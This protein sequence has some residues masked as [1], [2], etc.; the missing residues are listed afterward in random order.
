[1]R[2]EGIDDVEALFER[3]KRS[4]RVVD[5]L[6]SVLGRGGSVAAKIRL[7]LQIACPPLIEIR[8][9]T[10]GVYLRRH[11]LHDDAE[12][13]VYLHE[14]LQPDADREPHDH[15]WNG[16]SLILSGGYVEERWVPGDAPWAI[17]NVGWRI[18]RTDGALVGIPATTYHR[19]D[20]VQP[21]TFTLVVTSPK[22]KSWSFLDPRTGVVTPWKLFV[23]HRGVPLA[24]DFQ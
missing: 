22:L 15:P 7:W 24:G 5:L 9:P 23:E 18:E 1:M 8:H 16:A 6:E 11:V 4:Q 17:G 3:G 14:I 12:G 21:D 19:I 13:R 20:Q 10:S 2:F